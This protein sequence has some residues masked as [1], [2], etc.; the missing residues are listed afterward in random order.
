MQSS[1]FY[2]AFRS[3]QRVIIYPVACA[4]KLLYVFA[5]VFTTSPLKLIECIKQCCIQS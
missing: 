3:L 5:F 2:L 4:L 1:L